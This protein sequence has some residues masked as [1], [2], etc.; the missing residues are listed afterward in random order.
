MRSLL[1]IRDLTTDFSFGFFLVEELGG[2]SFGTIDRM[3]F[4]L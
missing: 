4:E 3:F 1:G 2:T